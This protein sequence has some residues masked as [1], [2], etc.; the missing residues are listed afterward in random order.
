MLRQ[1]CVSQKPTKKFREGTYNLLI[2]LYNEIEDSQSMLTLYEELVSFYP[3]KRYWVQ[4]SKFMANLKKNQNNSELLK[5]LMIK[6]FWIKKMSTLFY[7]NINESGS[8]L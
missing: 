4:L 8:A 1:Q 7:V 3:K 2:A 5:Q 6:D